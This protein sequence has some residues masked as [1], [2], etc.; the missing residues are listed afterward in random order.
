M[1]VIIEIMQKYGYSLTRQNYIELAFTSDDTDL[2]D[3]DPEQEAAIPYY[4]LTDEPR[5]FE[6]VVLIDDELLSVTLTQ[7]EW[8]AVEAG[9][10]LTKTGGDSQSYEFSFNGSEKP[11]ANLYVTYQ[12][13]GEKWD[14]SKCFIG[15]IK[16][17]TVYT[18]FE[19]W[20]EEM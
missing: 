9:A 16:D 19:R 3:L 6:V 8:S 14:S 17:A 2:N 5:Q 10:P 1:D 4:L 7:T 12:K 18:V 15:E 13:T 20:T 11:N